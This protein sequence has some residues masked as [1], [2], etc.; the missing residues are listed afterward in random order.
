MIDKLLQIFC[1]F[2]IFV[3][4]FLYFQES[5]YWDNTFTLFYLKVIS[6]SPELEIINEYTAAAYMLPVYFRLCQC[7]TKQTTARRMN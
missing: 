1:H 5:D 3:G 6:S 4:M 2:V 7:E